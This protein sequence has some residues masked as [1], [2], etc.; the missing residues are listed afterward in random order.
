MASSWEG[1]YRGDMGEGGDEGD[2]VKGAMG[3]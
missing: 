2:R 3:L 1:G